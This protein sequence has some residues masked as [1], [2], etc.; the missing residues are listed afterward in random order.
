[1]K[2]LLFALVLV[3]ALFSPAFLLSKP[4]FNGGHEIRV[5]ISEK[6]IWFVAD[7]MVVLTMPVEVRDSQGKV[8][9]ECQFSAKC[10]DWSLNVENLPSGKY[11][12]YIEN[13]EVK[14][15]TR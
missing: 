5:V 11:S 3:F 7:E 13:K 8:V 14:T 12:V 1:M 10:S 4:V 6:K 15:F 9:V 2:K